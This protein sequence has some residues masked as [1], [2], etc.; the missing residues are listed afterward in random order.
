MGLS[1][2]TFAQA[3]LQAGAHRV[4]S[5][6]Q[7]RAAQRAFVGKRGVK[8]A[9]KATVEQLQYPAQAEKEAPVKR[10][11]PDVA[12]RKLEAKDFT[13]DVV[14]WTWRGFCTAEGAALTPALDALLLRANRMVFEAYE[15]ANLHVLRLLRAHAPVPPLDQSFFYACCLGVCVQDDGQSPW[16]VSDAALT[17]SAARLAACRPE[18]YA[19][20]K[21]SGMR[22]VAQ[23][24][25]QQMAT[26][27][28]NMVMTT[29]RGRVWRYLLAVLDCST[30]HTGRV[31]NAVMNPKP[32]A[33][34]SHEPLVRRLRAL[35]PL[36]PSD[37]NLEKRPHLFMD[38]LHH[39]QRVLDGAHP[40]RGKRNKPF[41]LLPHKGGYTCQFVKINSNTLCQL[42]RE[43]ERAATLLP[44]AKQHAKKAW[45]PKGAAGS[46]SGG[47]D[48]GVSSEAEFL[49]RKAE[50][51]RSL[52]KVG[53]LETARRSF[54]YEML[55]DGRSVKVVMRTPKQ[56]THVE[57]KDVAL[58][59]RDYDQ[60]WGVDPGCRDMF[61]ACDQSYASQRCSSKEFYHDAKYAHFNTKIAA[62]VRKDGAVADLTRGMPRKKCCSPHGAEAFLRYTLRHLDALQAF[63]GARRFRN[64]RLTRHIHAKKKLTALCKRLT[65]QAGAH[66][67]I[68]FGDWSL[69]K[70]GVIKGCTPGP[71]GRLRKELRKYARVVDVDE[72]CTSKVCNCCKQASLVNMSRWRRSE[73]DLRAR[74]RVAVHGVL[75]CSTSGCLSRTINRDINASRNIL[76]LTLALLWEQQRPECFRRPDG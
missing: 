17:A 54:A 68:G 63:Y 32:N 55:T 23:T 28:S 5:E 38:L 19:A 11:R 43:A 48:P 7:F 56:P 40:D 6:D 36:P 74:R 58:D 67:L 2:L 14:T 65:A 22:V 10:K 61:V 59:P 66:T 42:V 57:A 60:V 45:Q 70:G 13:T 4:I 8:K 46:S 3:L 76:E 49:L 44:K 1:K 47:D 37:S 51:W 53:K 26:N 71:S 31:I 20:V 64:A 41:S 15:L 21:G 12:L 72:Y 75:H 73:S 39:V 25:S 52:F 50:W 24:L 18:G 29:L 62:W 27:V 34:A 16:R 33:P 69:G 9:D 35:M 30:R